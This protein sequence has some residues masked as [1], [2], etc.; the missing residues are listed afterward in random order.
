MM[1]ESLF[2]LAEHTSRSIF[3]TGKAG[4]GKTTFLNDF[5]TKTQK[6]YIVVA[7][8]GIAAIN[9]GGVTIHSMFGLPLR[10]FL[11]T[12]DRIDGNLGNNIAD[13]HQHFKYRKDKL[14]LL[15]EVEII[16]VD[17]VSMLR[18][19][20]LDMMDFS[21]RH[22][23]RNQQKFGGVQMLFIGDLYQLPPVVRDENI[24]KEFYDSPFFFDSLALK[25]LPLI[26]LEL[27]KVYRQKDEAFLEILNAIRDGNRHAV[28][29]DTLNERFD[30][31]FE[32]EEE[33][34]VYLTSHNRMA[35]EINQRKLKELPGKSHFF[36]AKITGDFR[37]NQYPN[38]ETLELKVG[39][40][41]MFIRNDA[42]S[43]RR[44]FNGKLAEIIRLDDEEVWVL[45]D[46][47]D[48]E[49]KLK[50]EVW[51]QKV[52]SL[53]A[54]K[55]IKEDVLGSFEQFPVRLAWAVTIHKS[56]GLTFDRLIIDAGKSFASGQVYV[57]LSRCRTLD[58]I[59]LKSKITPEVIFSDHRVENFQNDTNANDRI[60]EILEIEKYDYAIGKVLRYADCRWIRKSLEEWYNASLVSKNL[61]KQKAR[62]LYTAVKKETENFIAIY[63]KFEKVLLQKNRKFMQGEEKWEE[64]ELKSAGAINFFFKNIN[65]KIFEPLKELY[66]ET[67]GI[68]GLKTYND[69]F[70]VFLDD[71]EDY[72]KDLRT[73]RLLDKF[74]F[75]EKNDVK[76]ST[77]IEKVPSH[78][79]TYQMFEN[80]KTI[81][82]IAKERGLV[83]ETV[84]GHLAKFA[85]Q[86][87]LDLKRV[88]A[89]EKINTFEKEFKK[90]DHGSLNEWKKVL[91]AEFE[92]NEI[93]IL[94][95]HYNWLKNKNEQD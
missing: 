73:V 81:P 78:I 60:E 84:Y 52:Y 80:G 70:R 22:V 58:G 2:A 94:I 34:Y 65:E 91:P 13:L 40:Q 35:D 36:K 23:R 54:E 83:N 76:I 87:V 51:D 77:K 93:R 5:V 43:E 21:L 38:E 86:G 17:E 11:P 27:T 50:R 75:D 79:L 63:D 10:P 30:P 57:A 47:D 3:L 1:N 69:D 28:D 89:K 62:S 44:Y 64:V 29:F 4:T 42:S 6:K 15:R 8:T 24:L 72:L 32:P 39:T 90:G 82:E 7:P 48:E 85:E 92:F 71:L 41:I 33:A 9:A 20:V 19:D 16:I 88:L 45:I 55:N 66:A 56:Q 18:A 49:Y 31:N 67:K 59:V 61:D 74:L 14:K 46:G 68:K 26:T 53:D 95:N 37:E 25:E 12:T